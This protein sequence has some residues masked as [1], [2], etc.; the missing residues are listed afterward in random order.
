MTTR[1][2][3]FFDRRTLPEYRA[4]ELAECGLACLAM[5]ASYHGLDVDLNTL[6]QRFRASSAGMTL[7]ALMERADSLGFAARALRLEPDQLS[8]LALPCVL[9]WDLSH[10]VVLRSITK[11]RATIHDP[12]F[13]ARELT[14]DALSKHFTG[15]A[16][17]LQP[18]PRFERGSEETRVSLFHLWSSIRGGGTS[19]FQAI[20]LT[21]AL[22]ICAFLLPLQIQITLDYV[23]NLQ[24]EDFIYVLA[25]LF[26]AICLLFV[27]VEL[28]RD[29]TIQS[30]GHIFTYS[31]TSNVVRKLFSLPIS[32]FEARHVG[33]IMSR[34]MSTSSI[35]QI[36]AT[37]LASSIVDGGMAF[38]ALAILFYYSP[39]LAMIV[40][41]FIV[42]H[43]A[44]MSFLYPVLRRREAEQIASG[45]SHQSHLMESIRA[46]RLIRIMG[47]ESVR[48]GQWSNVF[49][50]AIRASL[51]KEKIR[52]FMNASE[53]LSNT[54]AVVIVVAVG[55]REVVAGDSLSLGMFVAFVSFAQLFFTR[56]L[57]MTKYV[58]MFRLLTVHLDRMGD[59][60]LTPSEDIRGDIEIPPPQ[61]A[62]DLSGVSFRYA[63]DDPN[64]LVDVS[65]KVAPG[66]F[67]GITG[68]S[69]SG[70][71]T[72]LKLIL[73]LQSPSS[74]RIHLDGNVASPEYVRAW[75][76]HV[77]VVSQDDKLLTGTIAENIALFDHQIDM[78][79]VIEV[80]R[81]ACVH[82]EIDAMPMK[83]LSL[84]GDMGSI[85]SGGQ[86]QR[87]LLARALYSRPQVLIL[88]EGTANIDGATEALIASAISGLKITRLTVA[89]RPALLRKADRV[90]VVRDGEVVEEPDLDK[91]ESLGLLT[92]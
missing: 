26:S 8:E 45:A 34:L 66:E 89:H 54:L 64:V 41:A 20:A 90:F 61:G 17:E 49:G 53:R 56:V 4:P 83:Y 27:A 75:R 44:V 79:R 28:L 9:H 30:L 23:V 72:L 3:S 57:A 5:I 48:L 60:V 74:G 29:W 84:V 10:Y 21:L 86:R 78:D 33:D 47:A 52:L 37:G 63:A 42:L 40:L 43:I 1:I 36:L 92:R 38:V 7:R 58:V 69:G 87:I 51:Q 11:K 14:L 16:L 91:I 39:M 55:S 85:L 81:A 31:V 24:N 25:G 19:A 32:Y 65:F 12:I 2:F 62:V 15:V 77:G 70:K 46:S 71:T 22:Q 68:S 6:R 13:G 67:V 50:S 80:A 73:G 82:D 76:R 35:Q 59:I 18:T 88:D